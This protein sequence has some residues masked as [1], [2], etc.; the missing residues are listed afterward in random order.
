MRRRKSSSEAENAEVDLTPMLDVTFI[1]LI[2]FIVTSVFL[3]EEGLDLTPPPPSNADSTESIPVIQVRIDEQ[4]EI[5]VN[6]R[7]TELGGV[8]A[9]IERLYAENSQ[10]AVM[11]QSH[12]RA[13]IGIAVSIIDKAKQAQIP[14]SFTVDAEG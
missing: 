13:R 7:F 2:F 10:S 11:V 5:Y 4:N 9:Q 12:P 3:D 1:L 14:V 8:R 6:S